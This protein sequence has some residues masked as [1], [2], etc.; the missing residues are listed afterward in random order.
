M[1]IKK[2]GVVLLS[3]HRLCG[4]TKQVAVKV[5]KTARSAEAHETDEQL[6]NRG[7]FV[8]LHRLPLPEVVGSVVLL[9]GLL[10]FIPFIVFIVVLCVLLLLLFSVR[11]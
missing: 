2:R 8:S 1:S 6:T 9:P 4:G 5:E 3:V 7:R 10:H 11:I